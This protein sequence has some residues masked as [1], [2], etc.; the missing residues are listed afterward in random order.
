MRVNWKAIWILCWGGFLIA[1]QLF[2]L[3]PKFSR[4]IAD[5][6][7]KT[8]DVFY[9]R[10][11]VTLL[12]AFV[13]VAVSP[14]LLPVLK[15]WI[16]PKS[17]TDSAPKWRD[18]RD[19]SA[20]EALTYISEASAWSRA[21]DDEDSLLRLKAATEVLEAAVKKGDLT[22]RGHRPGND[23]YEIIP[24]D[25]WRS[26][27]IDLSA[28]IDPAGSGGTSEIRI[29]TKGHKAPIYQALVVDRA[30]VEKRWPP[31][32]TMRR[33]GRGTWRGLAWSVGRR[34]RPKGDDQGKPPETAE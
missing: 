24:R 21:R 8:P 7:S 9:Q 30:A 34:R 18:A 19:L 5:T 25:Y 32:N 26:A 27:G 20:W 23:G 15:R 16:L 6:E 31:D 10:L 14:L 33:L 4:W 22:L 17:S 28:T 13:I 12:V 1:D 29:K 3:R 2:R 11:E